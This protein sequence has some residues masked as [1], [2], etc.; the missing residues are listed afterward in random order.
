MNYLHRRPQPLV[1]RDLKSPNLLIDEGW[2]MK[3]CDFNLSRF[4]TKEARSMTVATNP[5]WLAPEI[6]RG[7]GSG[8]PGDVFAFGV[9]MWEMLTW[10]LPWRDTN[11]YAVANMVLQGKRLAFPEAGNLPGPDA[12]PRMSRFKALIERC[13]SQNPSQRPTFA[14][15]VRE[16][17][18]QLEAVQGNEGAIRALEAS[19][20]SPLGPLQPHWRF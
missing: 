11:P 17:R 6:L 2:T 18:A 15:I 8:P 14:V 16:L 13:W 7:D 9:V 12:L 4:L 1:H 20:K 3:V 19:P 5:R 10:Q